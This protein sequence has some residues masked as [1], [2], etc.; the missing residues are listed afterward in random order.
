M[1]QQ[2]TVVPIGDGVYRYDLQIGAWDF[3]FIDVLLNTVRTTT[4]Q[5]MTANDV[6]IQLDV[7]QAAF[8]AVTAM[9]G[10]S[11]LGPTDHVF[12]ARSSPIDDTHTAYPGYSSI[13]LNT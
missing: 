5:D 8:V 7:K 10:S 9:A 1:I 2:V 4:P 3:N 12:Y 6:T 13:S 11:K